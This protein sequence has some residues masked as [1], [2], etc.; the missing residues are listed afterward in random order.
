MSDIW[1]PLSARKTP[2]SH[3]WSKTVYRSPDCSIRSCRNV[4]YS[5]AMVFECLQV[6]HVSRSRRSWSPLRQHGP[7]KPQIP[8]LIFR[9]SKSILDAWNAISLSKAMQLVAFDAA[10]RSFTGW[11]MVA[12]YPDSSGTVL[13]NDAV[14]NPF[15]RVTIFQ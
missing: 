6:V 15:A 11:K 12:R 4:D 2:N 9:Q 7:T 13:Q 3:P 8:D 10:Q 1:R 5:F 14:R